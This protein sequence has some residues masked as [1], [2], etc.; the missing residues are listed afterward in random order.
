LK[1]PRGEGGGVPKRKSAFGGPKSHGN[2]EKKY[3]RLVTCPP[4]RGEQFQKKEGWL[5]LRGEKK[6][7]DDIKKNPEG[8][9]PFPQNASEEGALIIPFRGGGIGGKK[10]GKTPNFFRRGGENKLKNQ[11]L[12]GGGG[13]GGNY[14]KV[15]PSIESGRGKSPHHVKKNQTFKK[16]EKEG[17]RYK[18]ITVSSRK[19]EKEGGKTDGFLSA[20]R[21]N[22]EKEGEDWDF[23][24][25]KILLEK[26]KKSL[27]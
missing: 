6:V 11:T 4:K 3:K 10:R 24:L 13:E 23:Q 14:P 21:G 16:E 2:G 18:V 27:A 5:G 26:R 17:L 20:R 7:P 8:G 22:S 15:P 9:T 19:G 1:L 25:G 12:D